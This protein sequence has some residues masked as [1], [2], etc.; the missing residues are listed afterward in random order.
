MRTVRTVSGN[1]V[2]PQKLTVLTALTGE[3]KLQ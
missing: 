2:K 3:Y 1:D